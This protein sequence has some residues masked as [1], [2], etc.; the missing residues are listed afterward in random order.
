MEAKMEIKLKTIVKMGVEPLLYFASNL[1][2]PQHPKPMIT[3]ICT[4]MLLYLMNGLGGFCGEGFAD[5]INVF[6]DCTHI[7]GSG[8]Y[9]ARFNGYLSGSNIT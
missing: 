9:G 7:A 6:Y 3:A 1:K 5:I 4:A 2:P 8:K